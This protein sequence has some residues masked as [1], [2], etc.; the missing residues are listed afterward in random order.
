VDTVRGEAVEL[1]RTLLNLLA[2]DQDA[3]DGGR[4]VLEDIPDVLGFPPVRPQFRMLVML[5]GLVRVPPVI[6]F[7]YIEPH[8]RYSPISEGLRLLLFES[9]FIGSLCVVS[10]RNRR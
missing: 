3:I 10:V 5:G 2:G 8:R 1:C 6:P 4:L 9:S 7:W